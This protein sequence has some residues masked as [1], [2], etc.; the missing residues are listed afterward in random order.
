[1]NPPPKKTLF[2]IVSHISVCF[3]HYANLFNTVLITNLCNDM[4]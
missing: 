1:M 3:R 2:L 4:K